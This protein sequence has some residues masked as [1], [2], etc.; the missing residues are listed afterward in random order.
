VHR[1]AKAKAE[2]KD[3]G[4]QPT[5]RRQASDMLRLKAEG[6]SAG[7]MLAALGISRASIL[8]ILAESAVPKGN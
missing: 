7:D 3:A 2:G 6:K 8:G 5:A 4:R 1:I